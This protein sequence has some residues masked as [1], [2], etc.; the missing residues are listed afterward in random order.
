[1]DNVKLVTGQPLFGVEDAQP[2]GCGVPECPAGGKVATAN[3]DEIRML[4]GV[5]DAFIVEGTGQATK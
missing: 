5:V 3:V 2:Q 1:M 4:P